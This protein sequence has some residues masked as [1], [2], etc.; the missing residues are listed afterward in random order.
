MKYS[1]C[2]NVSAEADILVMVEMFSPWK[3]FSQYGDKLSPTHKGF[4][5]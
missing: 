2:R 1:P 3:I 5:W 4:H